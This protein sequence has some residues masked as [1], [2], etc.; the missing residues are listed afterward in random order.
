MLLLPRAVHVGARLLLSVD[1]G[2]LPVQTRWSRRR[3]ILAALCRIG[4]AWY[5]PPGATQVQR[6]DARARGGAL[7][8]G[9]EGGEA[10]D[11][12]A[13]VL[14]MKKLCR[15]RG[16]AGTPVAREHVEPV[17]REVLRYV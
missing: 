7:V 8:A 12:L 6:T 9:I 13:R 1:A 2:Q 11:K 17:G 4:A 5:T 3:T 15:S 10:A 14:A 16:P